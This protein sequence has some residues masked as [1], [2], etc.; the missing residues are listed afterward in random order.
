MHSVCV[1][2]LRVPVNCIKTKSDARNNYMANYFAVKNKSHL[3]IH[4]NSLTV[5]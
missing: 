4:V 1:L 5:H 2:E 3:G